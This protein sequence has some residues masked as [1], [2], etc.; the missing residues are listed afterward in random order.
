MKEKYHC[1]HC[2]ACEEQDSIKSHPV[3]Q[4]QF[5]NNN[6][7]LKFNVGTKTPCTRFIPA[8]YIRALNYDSIT[9]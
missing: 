9:R 7:E 4:C 5:D 8:D 1:I 6:Q 3:Y 2:M